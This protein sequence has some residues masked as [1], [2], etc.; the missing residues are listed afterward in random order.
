M[1]FRSGKFISFEDI[2]S[3][4]RK[5]I[6]I[7]NRS[8][9]SLGLV[10]ALISLIGIS[11]YNILQMLKNRQEVVIYLMHG[12]DWPH[13][14]FV[15]MACNAII[16]FLPAVVALGAVKVGISAAENTDT[17]LY[18]SL[19]IIVTLGICAAYMLVS[20]VT[21]LLLYRDR[22]LSSLMRKG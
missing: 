17:M 2:D 12:M 11:G 7:G 10:V 16:V 19:N 6:I 15:E 8:F 9:I 21:V 14:F 18:S 1:L 5:Q 13:L 22:S 3:R 20:M 4:E